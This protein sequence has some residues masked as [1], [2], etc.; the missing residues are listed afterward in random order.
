MFTNEELCILYSR[1]RQTPL[2][3]LQNN[4]VEKDRKQKSFE[5]FD[6]KLFCFEQLDF[7][8]GIKSSQASPFC[9]FHSDALRQIPR[10]IHIQAGILSLSNCRCHLW[11]RIGIIQSL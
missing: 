9:L 4:K 7:L 8:F 11:S 5:D 1:Y 3:L 2:S 10:L 6:L